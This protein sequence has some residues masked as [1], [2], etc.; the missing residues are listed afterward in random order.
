MMS[1]RV[2][3]SPKV[4]AASYCVSRNLSSDASPQAK[5]NFF[6]TIEEVLLQDRNET[7]G[8]L[9]A[10]FNA[11][12]HGLRVERRSMPALTLG[13]GQA[14]VAQKARILIHGATLEYG[15]ESLHI[16]RK[17]VFSFLSDQGTERHLPFFPVNLEGNLGTFIRDVAE[18]PR[19]GSVNDP[20]LMPSALSMPGLL[21]IIFNALEEVI[22]QLP[23]WP[24]M[25]KQLSAAAQIVGD[26]GSQA[27]I[28]E[29][30][31]RDAPAE[32]RH[33]VHQ[34]S[35]KLLGWRWESLQVV[36]KQWLAVYPHLKHRWS[37]DIFSDSSAKLV[38][39][40]GAA[41]E[42]SWHYIF[43]EWLAMFAWAVGSEASWLEGCFCHSDL[44][45]SQPNRWQ[46]AKALKEAGVLGGSCQWQGRRLPA[47]ALGHVHEMCRR[48]TNASSSSYTLALLGIDA[49]FAHRIA[50]IDVQ[51]KLSITRLLKQKLAFFQS[52]PYS[53]VG[54][55]GEYCGHSLAA[56]KAAVAKAIAEFDALD[57]QLRDAVSS[58]LMEHEDVA[59]Q[60]RQ[61]A[62]QV[63]TP[64]HAFPDAFIL[65]RAYAFTLCTERRTEG[66]HAQVKHVSLRGFRFAGPVTIAARKRKLEV[67]QLIDEHMLWLSRMWYSRNIFLELLA[68]VMQPEEVHKLTFAQRCRRIYACDAKDHFADMSQWEKQAIEYTKAIAKLEVVSAEASMPEESKQL[69][70]FLKNVLGNGQLVSIPDT[71]WRVALAGTLPDH[72]HVLQP[73]FLAE[74]LQSAE[75]T[76][77]LDTL[78]T[79]VFFRVVEAYPESKV[80]VKLRQQVKR[81]TLIY[82]SYFP[83]VAWKS[84]ELVKINFDF[85]EHQILDLLAWCEPETFAQFCRETTVWDCSC[86]SLEL[87]L[88]PLVSASSLPLCL[89]DVPVDDDPL[90]SLFSDPGAG[91][92]LVLLA[93]D[94]LDDSGI[95][96][97]TRDRPPS[98]E[99]QRILQNL[100]DKKAFA[101]ESAVNMW[102]LAFFS[103]TAINTLIESGIVFGRQNDFGDTCLWI[104]DACRVTAGLQLSNPQRI[105]HAFASGAVRGNKR[106]TSKVTFFLLLLRDGWKLAVDDIT[107][108]TRETDQLLVADIWKRPEAYFRCMFLAASLFER[109]R[110]FKRIYHHGPA[111]Y[112]TELILSEDLKQFAKLSEADIKNFKAKKK[113]KKEALQDAPPESEAPLVVKLLEEDLDLPPVACK[114]PRF[115]EA[116][117]LY[118]RFTHQSGKLRCFIQCTFHKNCRKYTFVANHADKK[119]A[120]SWLFAWNALGEKHKKSEPHKLAV[121]TADDV[122]KFLRLQMFA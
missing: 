21:H 80:V 82:V 37:A 52:I 24:V 122:R 15:L 98:A 81:T 70:S 3:H 13:R 113:A 25:E 88:K 60:L 117:V 41:L 107:W 86:T 29:N 39:R 90:D 109:E 34:F 26:P 99:E 23:E 95:H 84:S 54:A 87:Q 112:Y 110:K 57:V 63:G 55:F 76:V 9:G 100:V 22:S 68:H 78:S 71:L 10:D 74:C 1:R 102:D 42:S 49:E 18:N 94:E 73:P 46:R 105:L 48:I 66:E 47:L 6:C 56:A 28:L 19:A 33:A 111:A 59:L 83:R 36:T 38:E 61:F 58:S 108:H 2:F 118:D 103:N 35:A 106:R 64:L 17:Q 30:L 50:E 89:P 43:L 40:V 85:A 75:E 72:M 69:V 20:V 121:P 114:E 45:Q 8:A 27:L 96:V 115:A 91:H 65:I 67:N 92:E 44:L 16:W 116:H 31:F 12:K 104:T 119:E 32:E 120:E 7:I 5:H 11:F 53:F 97:S 93:D 101:S 77:D 62:E 4:L 14:S 79:H 51:C